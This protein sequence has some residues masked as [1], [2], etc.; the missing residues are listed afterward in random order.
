MG[1]T[2]DPGAD[3]ADDTL[4]PILDE[5]GVALAERL[6]IDLADACRAAGF[7]GAAG[8]VMRVPTGGAVSAP[9]VLVVG[10]GP[11][12]DV[13][14]ESIRRAG[15]GIA[16]ATE[17]LETAATTLHTASANVQAEAGARAV[18]EGLELGAYR[19]A[20]YKSKPQSHRLADVALVGGDATATTAGITVGAVSAEATNLVRDLTNTVSGDKRP[21][22]YADRARELVADLPIEVTVLGDAELADGGYGGHL[23]V[24]AGSDVGARLVELR[25]RPANATRH[26]ALVGKGITFDSGGL[27][28]KPPTAM[29]WMKVDMAGSATALATIRAAAQLEL[30]TAV[31]AILCLAENMPS[32]SAT[33]PGDVLTILGGK[34]VE[35]LNTDAEGRLVLADG[36]QHAGSVDPKPDVLVDMATLTGGVIVAL[37]PRYTALISEDDDLAAAISAAADGAGEPLWRLPMAA[38][39]YAEELKSEVADVRNIGGKGGSTIRAALFLR[40]FVPDGITWAH[41]DIAGASWNEAAPFGYVPKGATGLPARTMIDWLRAG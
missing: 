28:L 6:G 16:E 13:T 41:L 2:R 10:L 30:D 12:A 17:R 23:G 7:D 5:S 21:P 27:S 4:A 11:A 40:E 20:A 22:D 31:T 37:G 1:A 24:S 38:A 18:V 9:L 8:T 26:V 35:V 33:R 36:L 3:D 25:Y 32:G 19:F 39:E 14:A 34:T 15:A 29:E